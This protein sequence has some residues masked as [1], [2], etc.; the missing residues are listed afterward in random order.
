MVFNEEFYDI[1]KSVSKY[2]GIQS[3]LLTCNKKYL[4]F[5]KGRHQSLDINTH[6]HEAQALNLH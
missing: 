1:L 6:F 3:I 5:S 4:I 2:N